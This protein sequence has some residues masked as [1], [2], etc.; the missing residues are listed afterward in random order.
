MWLPKTKILIIGTPR[1]G[2]HFLFKIAA[3]LRS[4]IA[5]IEPEPFNEVRLIRQNLL[6]ENHSKD[7][8]LKCIREKFDK[9]LGNPLFESEFLIKLNPDE[10]F[11]LKKANRF[12]SLIQFL[13]YSV[14]ILRKDILNHI[15]SVA[16][17]KK[18]TIYHGMVSNSVILDKSTVDISIQTVLFG[19]YSIV[20]NELF[21]YFNHIVSYEDLCN[22]PFVIDNFLKTI[23]D[24]KE[25]VVDYDLWKDY[26]LEN[27]TEIKS[28]KILIRNGK[29]ER[30]TIPY[31]L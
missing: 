9:T 22:M 12:D 17:A 27:I 3:H 19:V 8:L 15:L 7:E 28:D 29:L 11:N 4:N 31:A 30:I 13:P 21:P 2:T 14:L 25:I 20:N 26:I 23:P 6:S 10:L 1:S 18:T 16:I 5:H 24:K